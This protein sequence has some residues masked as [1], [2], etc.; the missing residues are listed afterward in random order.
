MSYPEYPRQD[1]YGRPSPGRPDAWGASQPGPIPLRPLSVGEILGTAVTVLRRSLAPLVLTALVVGVLSAAVTV[2][3]LAVAGTLQTYAQATWLEDVLRGGTSIPASILVSA[4]AGLVVS[5]AGAQVVAGVA[6]VYAGALAQGRDGRGEL[7]GRL[8]GRWP[9]LLAVSVVVGVLVS[10]GL[11]LLVVP[12]VLGYLVL[13]LA[14]PVVAMERSG[15]SESLRRS[16][17]LS[18]GRRGRIFGALALA[19]LISTVGGAIV[20]TVLSSL[21]GQH[22]PVTTLLITQGVGAVVGA[23]TGA[24]TGAVV[25]LLYIDIRIRTERLDYALRLAAD[26]DKHRQT[27]PGG[28]AGSGPSGLTPPPPAG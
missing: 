15:L 4:L 7:A 22:D 9:A 20:T 24:W 18:R 10:I 19:L 5:V 11:M 16:A 13:A 28:P 2:G 23:F 6:T 12:G 25:A 3:A 26:L 8:H 21:F 27:G 14:A 1:P 17:A